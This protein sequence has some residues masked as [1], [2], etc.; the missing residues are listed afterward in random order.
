M[1]FL[2]QQHLMISVKKDGPDKLVKQ[3]FPFQW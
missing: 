1:D 2:Q 3:T